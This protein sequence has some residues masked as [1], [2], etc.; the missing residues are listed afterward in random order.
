MKNSIIPLFLLV[1]TGAYTQP[2]AITR[3]LPATAP[4]QKQLLRSVKR[5][6]CSNTREKYKV[7]FI[8]ELQLTQ[9]SAAVFTNDKLLSSVAFIRPGNKKHAFPAN[10]AIIY[11]DSLRVIAN[12][13]NWQVTC[14][15]NYPL[16]QVLL[17]YAIEH[18][19]DC[20]F[21]LSLSDS[22]IYFATRDQRTRVVELTPDY[23]IKDY[24]LEE[25]ASCCL[26]TYNLIN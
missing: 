23:T 12:A 4:Y 22:R 13:H 24:S 8:Y 14:N 18:Q 17:Q 10:Q 7:L 6:G 21:R 5:L 11:N 9:R 19:V 16:P 25:F 3:Q 1:V 20:M 15:F 2:V 26:N